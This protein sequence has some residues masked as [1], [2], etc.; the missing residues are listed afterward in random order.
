MLNSFRLPL[1]IWHEP[2][3][4]A[5]AA[6]IGGYNTFEVPVPDDEELYW[7]EF[8]TENEEILPGRHFCYSYPRILTQAMC[9]NHDFD[10]GSI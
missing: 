2:R 3:A 4:I 5:A 7:T 6:L 8:C 10:H 1:C 9:R